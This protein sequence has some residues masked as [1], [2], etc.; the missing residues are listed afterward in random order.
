MT[1]TGRKSGTKAERGHDL[2]ETTEPAAVV[3]SL[4]SVEPVPFYLWEP[5]C[6]RGALVRPLKATGRTVYATD[7]V[8]YR[9]SGQDGTG[10]FLK[11]PKPQRRIGAIITNPPF[12]LAAS[13]VARAIALYPRAYFLLPL[14]F[15]E[16]G[17][18]SGRE[19][20][21][22]RVVLDH[23]RPAA[24]HVFRDRLPRM[25]RA[26]WDG[27]KATTNTAYAWFCWRDDYRGPTTIDR[28]SWKHPTA[29]AS[30]PRP[31]GDGAG[32]DSWGTE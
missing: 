15:M 32:V 4:L 13:F 2:Y 16:A 28:I 8:L 14:A 22:R 26:G 5:A 20:D 3:A 11:G 25:H 24:I 27:P 19:A 17:N 9:R 1:G 10:D 6:G 29:L 31:G 30:V 18:G 12:A 7:L 23:R 21:A